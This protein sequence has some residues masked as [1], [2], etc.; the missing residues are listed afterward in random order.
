VVNQLTR[1]VL[2]VFI[3]SPGDLPEERRVT[4]EVAHKLNRIIGSTLGWQIDVLGSE[5]T[6]PGTGRPQGKINK[7]VA[8]ICDLFIGLLWKRWG[9]STGEYSSG[10]EEEFECARKRHAEIGS[11]EIWLCFK[12]VDRAQIEDAGPQ[13]QQVLAFRDTQITSK[14]VLFKEFL[15]TEDWKEKLEEWLLVYILRLNEELQ[16]NSQIAPDEGKSLPQE[17]QSLS[18][19]SVEQTEENESSGATQLTELVNFVNQSINNNELGVNPRGVEALDRFYIARLALLAKTWMSLRYSNELLS[20]HEINL[21]YQYK[22]NLETTAQERILLFRTLIHDSYDHTAGWY[23]FQDIEVADLLLAL[24]MSDKDAEIQ[25]RALQLLELAR[26]CLTT[27]PSKR[28]NLREII[29]MDESATVRKAGLA[30]LGRTGTIEDIPITD[31]ALGDDDSSV[32]SEAVLAR[33]SI[34]VRTDPNRALSEI[35]DTQKV[36]SPEIIAEIEKQSNEIDEDLLSI[37]LQHQDSKIRVFALRTL[38]QRNRLSKEELFNLL[39]DKS[40]EVKKLCYKTLIEQG[41]EIDIEEAKKTLEGALH[42]TDALLLSFYRLFTPERLWKEI[43]WLS[44]DSPIAYQALAM[45]HFPIIAERIRSDLDT[46]FESLKQESIAKLQA[47]Y[48]NGAVD[49]IISN[50]HK[51]D[52]FTRN[53]FIAA[54]LAGLALH[55]E[56]QDIHWGRLYLSNPNSDIQFE[57]V[58]I[59]ERFGN[60]SDVAALID[61]AKKSYGELETLAANAALK[62]APG[63]SGAAKELLQTDD[64]ELVGLVIKSFW[65]EEKAE[66]FSV[67]EPLLGSKNTGI[68]SRVLVYFVKMCSNEEH[69]QLLLK[70]IQRSSYFYDVV[71]WLDRI[72]YAPPLLKDAF[73]HQMEGKIV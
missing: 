48:G 54:A 22:E 52:N 50:L 20:A 8:D 53:R 61:I 60:D 49:K 7:D 23:W 19:P 45:D 15:D 40:V 68:R 13:L 44:V 72:L 66:V 27:E 29:L 10:F 39:K 69:E 25:K 11:P 34:I 30:Y 67:L 63:I 56:S 9:S 24:G 47:Q 57:A 42:F 64:S 28:R 70:Y 18:L 55:G 35:L 6:L 32:R 43:D 46:N 38:V 58:R 73:V 14:E 41:V 51:Y 31:S 36:T 2:T 21:L 26:I 3:A 17:T 12:K 71:C 33:Q 16:K 5:E 59:V 37:A 4:R 65:A 62:L 1:N